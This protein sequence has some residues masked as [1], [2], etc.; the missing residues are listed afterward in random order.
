MRFARLARSVFHIVGYELPPNALIERICRRFLY[1]LNFCTDDPKDR[2]LFL[3]SNI[4][5]SMFGNYIIARNSKTL[6]L[7]G[8]SAAFSAKGPF[9]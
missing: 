9:S 4:Q 3:V 2:G 5:W 1:D 7:T 6:D 8:L